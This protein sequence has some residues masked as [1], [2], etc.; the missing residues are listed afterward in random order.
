MDVYS[1]IVLSKWGCIE[2]RGI[3]ILGYIFDQQRWRLS[4]KYWAH[5]CKIIIHYINEQNHN[6]LDN[7]IPVSQDQER[8]VYTYL[9]TYLL[10]DRPWGAVDHQFPPSSD[11]VLC[12]AEDLFRGSRTCGLLNL[13]PVLKLTKTHFS[14]AM[15]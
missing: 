5:Q 3:L 1:F 12:C 8:S 13:F 10:D 9:L 6:R 15:R 11:P 2:G 7:L 4:L 14:P